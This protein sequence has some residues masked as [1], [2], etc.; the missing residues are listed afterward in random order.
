M[1]IQTLLLGTLITLSA[2]NKDDAPD[3]SGSYQAFRL[4]SECT[5]TSKNV[6]RTF[7]ASTKELCNT[8]TGGQDCFSL[9]L[10]LNADLS[11]SLTSKTKQI[12][13]NGG[14]VTTKPATDNGTYTVSGNELTLCVGG[15][16]SCITLKTTS[17]TGELD[18]LS[19]N[20][21][22]CNYFYTFKKN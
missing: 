16:S 4:R 19:T 11:Y 5:E 10:T 2:C 20:S 8:V 7:D 18:W 6:S 22:G 15:G 17:V 14:L 12:R 3:F 21:S 1:K 9:S 13:A